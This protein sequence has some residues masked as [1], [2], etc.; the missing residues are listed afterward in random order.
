MFDVRPGPECHVV[1][2]DAVDLQFAYGA[3]RRPRAPAVVDG[4]SLQIEAGSIVGILGPNGSGKTTLLKLLSGALQPTAGQVRFDD[5]ALSSLSRRALADH[6]AVVP[7]ET[8]LAFDYTVL[9]IVLMGRYSKLGAFEIEGPE[10]LA[11]AARALDA[12]GSRHLADRAFPTLSG[13]EKQR[14]II[15]SAL[16]QLDTHGSPSE[17]AS[18]ASAQ[19]RMEAAS[20]ASAQSGLPSEAARN[21]SAQ[22]RMGLLVLDEP[23]ASLDLKYQ[24]E[25]AALLTRL[26]RERAMTILLSTHDLRFA[27][28]VCGH[29][30]LLSRGRV[31][32]QGTPAETLTPALVG[33]LYDLEADVVVPLLA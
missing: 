8:H 31:L 27:A 12:T 22:R 1:L 2:L 28:S 23:T 11:S 32:A 6:V 5:R 25:V 20:E 24:L 26:N 10:D 14:V 9:E 19:R 21:A 3:R 13:G 7:Q 17:A 16:A 30:V 29:V 33:T 4:V 18:E 15:A